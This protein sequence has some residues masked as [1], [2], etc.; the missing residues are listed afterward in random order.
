VERYYRI[1]CGNIWHVPLSEIIIPL[2]WI[3]FMGD[4]R[5]FDTWTL[6]RD[7]TSKWDLN[8]YYA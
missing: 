1:T 8:N 7:D 3:G 6:F 2:F 5:E 4:V